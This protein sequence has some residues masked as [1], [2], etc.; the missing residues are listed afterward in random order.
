MPCFH[1]VVIR[2]VQAAFLGQPQPLGSTASPE[3]GDVTRFSR[4]STCPEGDATRFSRPSTCPEPGPGLRSRC[5]RAVL[6]SHRCSEAAPGRV[7]DP[8]PPSPKH[9]SL[10]PET[11]F[12]CSVLLGAPVLPLPASCHAGRAPPSAPVRCPPPP[13]RPL[14]WA[15]L[16]SQS[17]PS[18]PASSSGAPLAPSPS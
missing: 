16:H 5:L 15:L 1:T 4:P 2:S 7:S 17:F 3:E 14:G 8:R 6:S 10:S 11:D 12:L 9:C 13:P 18:H